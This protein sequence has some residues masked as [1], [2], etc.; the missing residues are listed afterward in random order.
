M[1]FV[2][3]P[4]GTLA[5]SGQ[6]REATVYTDA[7]AGALGGLERSVR[8]MGAADDWRTL[9]LAGAGGFFA[10]WAA[11]E[12]RSPAAAGLAGVALLEAA[13]RAWN[14]RRGH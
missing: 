1:P 5:V 14:V 9:A 11:V 4:A 6:V 8:S 12:M 13:R 10:S 3:S 7:V 2:D